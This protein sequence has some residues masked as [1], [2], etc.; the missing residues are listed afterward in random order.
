MEKLML[1]AACL[2]DPIILTLPMVTDPIQ[3]TCQIHPQVMGDGFA[4]FVIEIDRIH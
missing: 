1:A 2:P 3:Q 4:V